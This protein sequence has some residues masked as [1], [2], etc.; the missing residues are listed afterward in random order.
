MYVLTYSSNLARVSCGDLLLES[1]DR[2]N[3]PF[4]YDA[5]YF[6]PPTGL[7]FKV[8]ANEQIPL[9][10]EEI[11][12]CEHYCD[13]F[14]D[15]AD[16]PVFACDDAGVFAG[17]M[18]K[19][20]AIEKSL[21]FT[22]P[23]GPDHPASK[24]VG[25][26]WVRIRASILD[27]GR[28]VLDPASICERCII[29]LT[30]EEWNAFPQPPVAQDGEE[31]RWNFVSEDW[32]DVSDPLVFAFD[33]ADA[34]VGQHKRST[35]LSRGWGW[36][37]TPPDG[38]PYKNTPEGW[39]RVEAVIYENGSYERLPSGIRDDAILLFTREEWA[40]WPERP[41]R[42]QGN[43]QG[44]MQTPPIWN[45]NFVTET[46]E[47]VSNP[48]GCAFEREGEQAGL[49]V[50]DMFRSEAE[51]TGFGFT[52]D[53]PDHPVSKWNGEKWERAVMALL[54]DGSVRE[55]PDM[56]CERCMLL[57]T[58]EEW[59]AWPAPEREIPAALG[60][61]NWNFAAETWEDRRSLCALRTALTQH[62]F[63]Q[64]RVALERAA[65]D[66]FELD[67]IW[68]ALGEL[69]RWQGN[70]TVATPFVDARYPDADKIALATKLQ[71]RHAELA[72]TWG[73]IA[74]ERDALLHEIANCRNNAA[75]DVVYVR[76]QTDETREGTSCSRG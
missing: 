18:H 68:L 2:P 23:Q 54:D 73:R 35:V 39:Q 57:L 27:D 58:A 61:W 25:E 34:Y 48:Y 37:R 3:L 74:A 4:A 9:T 42:E 45:W 71:V 59:A 1:N 75:L 22:F 30:S 15:S 12:V 47:D 11:A 56:V 20:E 49:Y 19:S 21:K 69:R 14:L 53:R 55:S 67:E 66:P 7:A 28:L 43:D 41:R 24:W 65:S 10:K 40:A 5:L 63:W 62:A 70:S 50:G 17:N 38:W 29:A 44:T 52:H 64:C 36:R 76:L 33:E 51:A 60:N 6:E 8:L 16:Y 46:W 32:Q 72:A 13:S 31:Y 26:Q